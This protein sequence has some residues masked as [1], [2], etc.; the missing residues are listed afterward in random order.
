MTIKVSNVNL[1]ISK[2]EK[3]NQSHKNSENILIS[4][5]KITLSLKL[6]YYLTRKGKK[7]MYIKPKIRFSSWQLTWSAD[8][9]WKSNKS[10]LYKNT[11]QDT[12]QSLKE[13]TLKNGYFLDASE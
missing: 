10:W 9:I 11:F 8:I 6:C 13:Q 1:K 7:K 3:T 5:Y 12:V 4:N 2:N